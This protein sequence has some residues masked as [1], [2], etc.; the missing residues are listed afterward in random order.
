MLGNADV[1]FRHNNADSRYGMIICV[2]VDFDTPIRIQVEHMVMEWVTNA[3]RAV[4]QETDAA[5]RWHY[6]YGARHDQWQNP[7]MPSMQL[8]GIQ[9]TVAFERLTR[10]NEMWPLFPHEGNERPSLRASDV[11]RCFVGEVPDHVTG[12]G[13]SA[14]GKATMSRQWRSTVSSTSA[15]FC[16]P[17][18][19]VGRHW[20]RTLQSMA[21][22]LV[23]SREKLPCMHD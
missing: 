2:E 23:F 1:R 14:V 17:G 21:P 20:M 5:N 10:D 12:I 3:L 16:Q 22:D 4:H 13:V 7:D 9:V 11:L 15:A 6:V 8:N 19:G 18:L